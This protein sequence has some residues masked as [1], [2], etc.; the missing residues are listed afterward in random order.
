MALVA[1]VAMIVAAGG[2]ALAGDL[3]DYLEKAA[4][5]DYAGRRI[6]VTTWV[7]RT[8]AAVMQ[9]E[10]GEGVMMIAG[11]SS[12]VVI[13]RGRVA[14]DGTN[15]VALSGWS[16]PVAAARY[17]TGEVDDVSRLGRPARSVTVYEGDTLRAR[18]VF[19]LA[20]WAPLATEI[21]DDDGNLFRF[22]AF[23]E[24][25]AAPHRVY[26]AL[27][28]HE[29]DAYD[30]VARASSSSVP[31]TAGGYTLL[32]TYMGADG[33]TQG[34]YGDGLFSFSVFVMP[35]GVSRPDLD[36][37]AAVDLGGERYLVTVEPNDVWVTWRHGNVSYV[38]V[39]DLPPDHLELV[40]GS[41]P[42]PKA[43]NL[44][45]RVLSLFG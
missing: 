29:G 25:D 17:T 28:E 43:L 44:L 10:H 26:S 11:E 31:A 39:G 22:A 4:D 36:G 42:E 16:S 45:Q 27:H 38:L 15:G 34:F 8:E 14:M 12:D 23:T 2:P 20:T 1:A 19:D 32:D 21:Y 7:G 5:A 41:L 30:V 6:V 40:L 37:A 3:D 35:S 18:I 13:G 9:V 33:V 24:F